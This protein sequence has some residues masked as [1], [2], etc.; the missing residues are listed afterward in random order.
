[1]NIS[2]T[3]VSI[4]H[5]TIAVAVSVLGAAVVAALLANGVSAGL[6]ARFT[7]YI[8]GMS[9]MVAIIIRSMRSRKTNEVLLTEIARLKGADTHLRSRM[10]YMLRDAVGDIVAKADDVVATP[11]LP[12]ED[13]RRLLASIR[14]TSHEIERT[15]AEIATDHRSSY[16]AAAHIDTSILV[17]EELISI[18]STSPFADRFDFDIERTRAWGD[19]AQVRQILR[20]LVNQTSLGEAERLTL[21][22][23]Q[24]GSTATATVSGYGA[25][26]SSGAHAAL[27]EDRGTD[28]GSDGYQAMMLARRLAE[29]LGGDISHVHAF[30]MSH[31]VLTLPAPRPRPATRSVRIDP[32]SDAVADEL[33]SEG[34]AATAS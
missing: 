18:A 10:H 5:R 14:D 21:Q 9:A 2:S 32:G 17:G 1:M 20:T 25:I 26:L 23:T 7:I 34:S 6:T 28:G 16:S 27:S 24:R 13:Q 15:L 8:V 4:P 19:P 30:G 12:Y 31:V 22:T 29:E 33:L 3:Q 11:D